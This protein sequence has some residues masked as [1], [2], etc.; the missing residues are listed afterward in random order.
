MDSLRKAK[1]RQRNMAVVFEIEGVLTDIHRRANREAYNLSFKD[2]DLDC[3]NWTEP[4]YKDL[5][6][7]VGGDEERMLQVFFDR[8]GWPLAVPTSER[9]TFTRK[10][11]EIKKKHLE[12]FI[13]AGRLPLRPGVAEFVQEAASEGVALVILGVS[14]RIGYDATRK[15][16]EGLGDAVRVLSDED[17]RASTYAQVAAGEGAL[18][19]IDNMLARQLAEAVNAEKQRLAEMVAEKLKLTVDLDTG[20]KSEEALLALRAAAELAGTPVGRCVLLAGSHVGV[21]AAARISMPCV[22]VKSSYTAGAEFPGALATYG[23]YGMGSGVTLAKLR[24]GLEKFH[25]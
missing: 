21:Q 7:S 13:E 25:S 6:R 20:G 1:E 9:K 3:A 11:L 4:V 12:S 19:G 10:C 16:V 2:L 18:A 15:L 17:V 14:S 22:V 8:I 23:D 5:Y 24:R